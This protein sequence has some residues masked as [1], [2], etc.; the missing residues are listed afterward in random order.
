MSKGWGK[1]IAPKSS[2]RDVMSEDLAVKLDLEERQPVVAEPKID[3]ELLLALK[4]SEQETK[5]NNTTVEEDK[6]LMLAMRLQQEFI[7]EA[8]QTNNNS[9]SK[10]KNPT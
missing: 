8:Q 1:V 2:F 10:G 3:E 9:L 4:L 5:N 7:R 6:D